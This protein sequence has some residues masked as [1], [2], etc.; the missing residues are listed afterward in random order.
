MVEKEAN[1]TVKVLRTDRGGEFTSKEFESFCENTG[2]KRHLTAPYTPQKN[3]VVERRN[4]T[5]IAMTRSLLKEKGL[6]ATMWGEAVRHAIY[7]LNRL[8]TKTLTGKTPYEVW[9]GTKPRLNHIR[10]FGCLA[11][12]KVQ[13][14]GLGKLDDRSVNMV[15]IGKEPGTKAH[16]LYNPTT[17]RLHISRDVVFEEGK[18]WN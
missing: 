15:Y 5:M 1:N 10:V 6:P 18:G 14:N 2:I 11:H 13:S 7:L 8:P 12:V 17:G 16:R 4:R 9:L 3:G